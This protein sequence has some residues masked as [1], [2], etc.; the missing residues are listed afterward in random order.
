MAYRLSLYVF[1]MWL[2]PCNIDSYDE[3][4]VDVTASRVLGAIIVGISHSR[5]TTR[6]FTGHAAP[7]IA[8]AGIKRAW[9]GQLCLGGCQ[10][11]L[12]GP[13]RP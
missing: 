12:E 5:Q 6:W 1:V 4:I 2:D 3:S 8:I 11:C 13:V 10:L 7:I 9:Q